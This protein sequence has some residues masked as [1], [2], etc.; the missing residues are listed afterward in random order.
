MKTVSERIDTGG[1]YVYEKNSKITAWL[2]EQEQGYK[3]FFPEFS[4]GVGAKTL[5]ARKVFMMRGSS[6]FYWGVRQF[7]DSLGMS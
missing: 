4:F 2:S 5:T 7:Q 6:T 1:I 3:D